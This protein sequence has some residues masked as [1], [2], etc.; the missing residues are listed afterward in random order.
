MYLSVPHMHPLCLYTLL[1]QDTLC[2][3]EGCRGIAVGF[4]ATV[5]YNDFIFQIF[6]VF[7]VKQQI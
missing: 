3:M 1:L 4:R 7:A 6:Y 2:L 5:E